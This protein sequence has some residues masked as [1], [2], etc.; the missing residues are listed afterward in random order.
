MFVCCE[1]CVLSGRGLCDGLITRPEESYRL[2]RVV[3][4][5]RYLAVKIQPQLVVTPGKQTNKQT[6]IQTYYITRLNDLSLNGNNLPP[7]VWCGLLT[8]YNSICSAVWLYSYTFPTAVSP[9]RRY[10]ARSHTLAKDMKCHFCEDEWW[11][12]VP[13]H[14]ITKHHPFFP[15]YLQRQEVSPS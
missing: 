13:D 11:Y 10:L 14:F 2:W 1:C 12:F 3:A 6:Y 5:A 9:C 7:G 15:C 8:L 4:K